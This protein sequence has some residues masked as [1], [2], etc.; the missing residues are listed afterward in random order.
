MMMNYFALKIKK[1]PY[2]FLL[3]NQF[4]LSQNIFENQMIDF[5]KEY[6]KDDQ[7]FELFIVFS[8][9]LLLADYNIKVQRNV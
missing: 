5:L 3:Q 7:I 4:L 2:K 8:S 1:T 9:S 6:I